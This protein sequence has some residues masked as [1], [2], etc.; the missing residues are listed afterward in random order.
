[1]SLLACLAACGGAAAVGSPLANRGRGGDQRVIVD[2][3]APLGVLALPATSQ[4]LVD[5]PY[6]VATTPDA[7]AVV[8]SPTSVE[9]IAGTEYVA[10]SG[11]GGP[12]LRLTAGAP[13]MIRF[14]CD[15]PELEV[16]PLRGAPAP[17][18]IVWVLP[19]PVPAGWAPVVVPLATVVADKARRKW[20]AG[21]LELELART[22]ATHATFRVGVDGTTRHR[23]AVEA[24]YMEGAGE[25]DLDLREAHRPGIPYPE[26]VFAITP[27]GPYAVVLDTSGY[28]GVSFSM[29]LVTAEGAYPVEAAGMNVYYCAF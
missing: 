2:P 28:E 14:G 22:D 23:A 20:T 24:Y 27:N 29:L 19:S 4:L 10:V 13:T 25:I 18:A 8:P 17:P 6:W 3:S 21:A 5:A 9:L 16:V 15:Q 26:A 11:A 1:M 7:A 12:P